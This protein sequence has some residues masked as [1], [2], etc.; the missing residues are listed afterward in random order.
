[1]DEQLERVSRVLQ[2]QDGVA[3]SGQIL[4]VIGRHR[5]NSIGWSTQ[6][7]SNACGRESTAW[8]NPMTARGFAD[9]TCYA[10]TLFRS[11]WQ[12]QQPSTASTSKRSPSSMCSIRR[13]ISYVPPTVL[14][15][16][17]A[18]VRHSRL[19]TAALSH[20][21]LG[22]PSRW[23]E[24]CD[25]RGRWP[26]WTP[27]SAAAHAITPRHRRGS[28]AVAAR[29]RTGR[30]ADGDRGSAGHDLR[31]PPDSRAAIRNSRR[32]SRATAC[33]LRMAR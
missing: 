29:R 21:L 27:C 1:M 12:P 3:T 10:A 20:R 6:V 32:K 19:L 17:D 33:G 25:A 2:E 31:R 22:L 5:F 8:A 18:T 7:R 24:A 26:H 30:V 9:S 28:R 15:Y 4:R 11:A 14:W 23:P 13:V 16:I